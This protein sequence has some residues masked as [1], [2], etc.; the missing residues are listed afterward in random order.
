MAVFSVK[1]PPYHV[2]YVEADNVNGEFYLTTYNHRSEHDKKNSN[3][4][5]QSAMVTTV[6]H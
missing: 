5:R 6:L 1:H 2:L 3:V 4:M